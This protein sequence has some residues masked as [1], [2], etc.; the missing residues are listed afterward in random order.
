M[1]KQMAGDAMEVNNDTNAHKPDQ[2]SNFVKE[3]LNLNKLSDISCHQL[4]NKMVRTNSFK[5]FSC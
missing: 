5:I 4:S 2:K 1:K 3:K